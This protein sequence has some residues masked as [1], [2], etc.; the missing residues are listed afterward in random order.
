MKPQEE[1]MKWVQKAT[2][3]LLSGIGNRFPKNFDDFL[4]WLPKV[5]QMFVKYD[6]REI[7]MLYEQIQVYG[8]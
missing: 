3:R 6:Y 1:L 4:I 7:I 8:H 2:N 5:S